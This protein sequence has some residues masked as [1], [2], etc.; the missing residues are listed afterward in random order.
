MATAAACRAAF[1]G[2]ESLS[3]LKMSFL[4]TIKEWLIMFEHERNIHIQPFIILLASAL[5]YALFISINN[6]V[7]ENVILFVTGT[8]ALIF[9]IIAVLSGIAFL[10][11]TIIDLIRYLNYK[12]R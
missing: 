3:P 2:F 9:M 1:R 11:G 7:E 6:S 12:L 8:F 4:K 5:L 10:T